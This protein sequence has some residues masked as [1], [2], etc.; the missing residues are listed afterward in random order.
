MLLAEAERIA[1]AEFGIT[2]LAVLSGVGARQYYV[3]SGYHLSGAY[4]V[5]TLQR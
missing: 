4:M 2:E 5:K 3:E 1:L